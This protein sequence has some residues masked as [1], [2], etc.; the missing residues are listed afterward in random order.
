MD[1]FQRSLCS[2]HLLSRRL[3]P[4]KLFPLAATGVAV[5]AVGLWWPAVAAADGPVVEKQ[6][7][8]DDPFARKGGNDPFGGRSA[9]HAREPERHQASKGDDP[10]DRGE[11]PFSASRP[12]QE[13]R[14]PS[15]AGDAAQRRILRVLDEPI[16]M[17][18]IETPL[19]DAVRQMSETL[20]IPILIET[21][22]L[23]DMGLSADSPVSI[24]LKDVTTGSFLRLML[25]PLE[26]SYT[27]R[28]EVLLITSG[29]AAEEIVT[30]RVYPFPKPLADKG[31]EVLA[32][33]QKTVQPEQWS[34]AGGP[35][36]AAVV[37]NV[38]TVSAN[39]S[40]HEGIDEFLE[41]LTDA[42][43]RHRGR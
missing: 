27:I 22:T 35:C 7:T 1:L 6:T 5:M 41:K 38:M 36:S 14:T 31:D 32:A 19:Q 20:D 28:D 39:L 15:H 23:E 9:Q 8:A 4:S 18:F 3:R 40:V 29:Q 2:H 42:F 33:M 16:S 34:E 25:R 37:D 21:R 43:E 11:D 24:S 30:L 12:S 17:N 13:N 10:F 26:L